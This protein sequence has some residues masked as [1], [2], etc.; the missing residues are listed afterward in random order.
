MLLRKVGDRC[1]VDT[2]EIVT[3]FFS[4][5]KRLDKNADHKVRSKVEALFLEMVDDHITENSY[6]AGRNNT[7]PHEKY[8][9]L[10]DGLGQFDKIGRTLLLESLYQ[11]VGSLMA[12]IIEL[13]T[14][15]VISVRKRHSQFSLEVGEDYR[16][17]EW[18]REHASKYGVTYNGGYSW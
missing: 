14:W 13:P 10:I 1:I 17:D 4:Q 15:N 7:F 6:W 16:I 2:H 11:T 12:D 9:D 18:M 5:V 8:L 3:K